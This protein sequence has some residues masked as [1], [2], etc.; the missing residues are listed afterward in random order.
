MLRSAIFLDRDGVINID[1]NYVYKISDFEWTKEAKNAIKYINEKGYL[2]F[3]VTNQSGISKGYYSED[4]VKTLHNFINFELKKI[5]AKVDEFFYSPYH[6]KGK[7]IEYNN[8]SHLR[9]PNTGM[10]ELACNKWPIDR[11]KSILIGDKIIDMQCAK[12]FGITGYL[13][14]DKEMDLLSFIK[15]IV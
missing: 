12:N 4:D 7:I 15:N 8:L 6:P 13:F 14:D 10:L 11:N 3:I 9:K 1:K 5:G 2:V